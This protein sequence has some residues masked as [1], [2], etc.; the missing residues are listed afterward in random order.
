MLISPKILKHSVEKNKSWDVLTCH[1]LKNTVYFSYTL[2]L[3]QFK[4]EMVFVR[5][6]EREKSVETLVF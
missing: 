3:K 5:E 2:I 4:G 6:E 1:I